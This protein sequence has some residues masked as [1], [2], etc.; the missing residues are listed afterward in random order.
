MPAHCGQS[1][2]L[3]LEQWL[4]EML[5]GLSTQGIGCILNQK[6]LFQELFLGQLGLGQVVAK[7]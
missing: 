1:G 4:Q 7:V 6:P 2:E 5:L 3:F